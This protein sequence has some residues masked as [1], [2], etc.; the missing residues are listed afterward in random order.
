MDAMKRKALDQQLELMVVH[1]D[2]LSVMV[3][4]GLQVEKPDVSSS[5]SDVTAEGGAYSF[6]I[7]YSFS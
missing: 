7:S 2:K 6:N 1:A 5:S 4:E 3:Q